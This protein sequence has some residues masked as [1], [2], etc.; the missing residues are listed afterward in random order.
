MTD[1]THDNYRALKAIKSISGSKTQT[2]LSS[3][4][5]AAFMNVSQQ[6]A[7]RM[8]LQLLKNGY[9]SRQMNGRKQ[10]ISITEKGVGILIKEYTD[11][12]LLLEKPSRMRLSGTVQSGLGEG[13][14]YISRKFY[15]VQFQEKLG[16]IPFLGTLNLKIKPDSELALRRL[17]SMDGIHIDGFVAEDRSYGPVKAFL[18]QINGVQCA[19]IFPERSVYSDVLEIISPIYLRERLGINDGDQ[20]VVD[21]EG[22]MN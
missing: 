20:I 4:E 6:S 17:R 14:Y 21:V 15:I 2:S 16:Y 7:S 1:Q 18:C 3:S 19:V 8:I 11:L 13:R 9:I 10:E 12:G 22:P 5:L